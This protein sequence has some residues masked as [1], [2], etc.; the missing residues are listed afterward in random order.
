[1]RRLL[2][3]ALIALACAEEPKSFDPAVTEAFE[4]L[5]GAV[6]AKDAGRLYDLSPK[7]TRDLADALYAEQRAALDAVSDAYPAADRATALESL[8]GSLAAGA[9]SGRDLF[10]AMV[11]WSRVT[12][13]AAADRGLAIDAVTVSDTEAVLTTTGGETFRFVKEEGALRVANF[14]AQLEASPGLKKLRANL[15]IARKNLTAWDK[16]ISESTDRSKPEGTF[17]VLAEAVRRGA[18]VMVYELLDPLSRTELTAALKVVNSLQAAA[19][20]AHP[21]LAARRAALG[22]K[23]LEWVD[24]IADERSLFVA[25]WDAGYLGQDLPFG[26]AADIRGVDNKGNDAASVRVSLD[27]AAEKGFSFVR[28]EVGRWC[29]AGLSAT[30]QREGTRRLE[31]ELRAWPTPAP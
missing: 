3:V 18:R 25:L 2:A 6:R 23:K 12:L 7:A 20:K 29:F 26:A 9:T 21:D 10:I 17:N 1:M 31:A 19:E 11:D 27:G 22:A 8:G 13:D 16:A 14:G 15:A 24:R 5:V 4:A 28:N 30:L